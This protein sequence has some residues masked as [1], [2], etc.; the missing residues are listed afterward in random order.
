MQGDSPGQMSGREIAERIVQR[1]VED[2]AFRRRLLDEPEQALIDEGFADQIEE[3]EAAQIGFKPIDPGG[4]GQKSCQ[5]TCSATCRKLT[6]TG[7]YK[8]S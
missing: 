1:I 8:T 3:I 2:E 6:C 4:P 5:N 7:D